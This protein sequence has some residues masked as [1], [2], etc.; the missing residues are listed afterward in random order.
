M[1]TD[2]LRQ[3]RHCERPCSKALRGTRGARRR[4]GYILLETVVATGLLV[5]GLAVIGAQV[6]DSDTSV[7]TMQRRIVALALAEQQL[8]H[9]DLGLVELDSVD[10]VQ[11]GDFGPRHPDWGWR[12]TIDETN[13]ESMFLLQLD[14][15]YLFREDGYREDDFDYDGAQSVHTVYA[16]RPTPRPVSFEEELGITGEE[17]EELGASLAELGIEGLSADGFNP[18]VLGT[19]NF[20]E[21]LETLP[22]LMGALHLDLSPLADL[23]PAN[24][25]EQIRNAGLLS[26]DAASE[27]LGAL[28]GGG[29]QP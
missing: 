23:L 26:D 28:E 4:R 6:Q 12:L 20:E 5:V 25:L 19:L 22:V 11:E 16:M 27:L 8:A 9:L 13:L 29:V 10:E 2:A 1:N 21:M 14:V 24:L 3:P 17:L 15:L 18:A 7:R